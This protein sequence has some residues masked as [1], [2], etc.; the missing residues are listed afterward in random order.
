M[1][2]TTRASIKTD[3]SAAGAQPSATITR[4]KATIN[5]K[6]ATSL[7]KT[8]TSSPLVGEALCDGVGWSAYIV[9]NELI[10]AK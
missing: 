1:K 5:R 2:E 6:H 7:I 9:V 8:R 3:K 10:L 4:R